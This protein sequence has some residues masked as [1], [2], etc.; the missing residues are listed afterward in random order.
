[1]S[2]NEFWE[3]DPDLFWVYRFSYLER[4]RRKEKLF[5][6]HAWLQGAYFYEAISA[7]LSRA[8]GNNQVR[9]LEKPFE[10]NETE[11]VKE[12]QQVNIL[13]EQ[14]KARAKKVAELIKGAK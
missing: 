6:E 12:K 4:E 7:S 9:Y 3:D 11:Q 13:E 8:F 2:V 1:M 14:I 10:L 5:N